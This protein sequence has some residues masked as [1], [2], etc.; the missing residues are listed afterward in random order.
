MAL[1][2][3][4][5]PEAGARL[6][7]ADRAC[8]LDVARQAIA[9]A[10]GRGEPASLDA[11][12]YPVSLRVPRAS[13][14]TLHYQDQLRGCI[15]NLEAQRPLVEDVAH[16]ACAAAFHD[17][18]FTPLTAAELEG[19]SIHIAVLQTAQPLQFKSEPELRA[20]LQPGVDGVILEAGHHRATFLP[21]V[22]ESLPEPKD[23]LEQL[24]R[25]AGLT[26]NYWSNDVRAWRYRTESFP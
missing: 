13:F 1:T 17:P 23:F 4:S 8:L 26:G 16:N 11:Q 3:S 20:Q 6:S 24:K 25:K 5:Q 22:W 7:D 9:Q 18:R 19:L 21:A 14:V 2:S 10:L 15:G 12:D